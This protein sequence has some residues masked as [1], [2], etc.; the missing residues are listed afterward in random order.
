MSSSW[1]VSVVL[2]SSILLAGCVGPRALTAGQQYATAYEKSVPLFREAIAVGV[3]GSRRAYARRELSAAPTVA[4]PE[5]LEQ[6]LCGA[7]WPEN[8]PPVERS[9]E[10]LD[11]YAD[12]IDTLAKAPDDTLAS[13]VAALHSTLPTAAT[14]IKPRE[15][16]KEIRQRNVSR[17]IAFVR[18]AQSPTAATTDETKAF[19]TKSIDAVIGLLKTLLGNVEARRREAAFRDLVIKS[20]AA[21]K[22]L[23]E[24]LQQGL[25]PQVLRGASA[26]LGDI[27]WELA[28]EEP[29]AVDRILAAVARF[30]RAWVLDTALYGDEGDGLIAKFQRANAQVVER[31]RSGSLSAPELLDDLSAAIKAAT[32]A[33]GLLDKI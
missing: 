30:D 17:C 11:G 26:A 28:H 4:S 5:R 15:Q 8:D 3:E 23:F 13:I 29:G 18:L 9:V 2:L 27:S 10:N 16:A 6:L 33:Q 21:V 7:R 12:A 25:R 20:D 19:T 14:A 1:P 22:D 32:D 24:T 31:A